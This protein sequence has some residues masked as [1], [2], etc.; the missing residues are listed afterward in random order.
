MVSEDPLCM[1]T[2]ELVDSMGRLVSIQQNMNRLLVT[3]VSK[4][5]RLGHVLSQ[6]IHGVQWVRV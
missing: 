6:L 3:F 2:K 5:N 1:P 4:M